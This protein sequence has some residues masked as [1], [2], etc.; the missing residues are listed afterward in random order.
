MD[1]L[2]QTYINGLA[3]RASRGS[4]D[5]FAELFAATHSLQY[6]YLRHMLD[7]EG[8]AEEALL[9]VYASALKR[10]STLTRPDLF[11]PWISRI[12]LLHCEEL[13]G[14]PE[15][16]IA[17]SD[18]FS[19]IMQL[20]LTESQI[21]VMGHLQGIS[22]E[23][24]SYM[25]NLKPTVIRRERKDA[26]RR[27][28][29]SGIPAGAVRNASAATA[30]RVPAKRTQARSMKNYRAAEIPAE[31]AGDILKSVF[32]RSGHEPNRMPLEALS[33]Y[34][35]Y[36]RDRFTLQRVVLGTGLAVFLLL[37]ALFILPGLTIVTAPVGER[38]LPVYTVETEKTLPVRRVTAVI[39]Q[40]NLP[41]YEAAAGVYTIEP[42]RNGELTVYV[43]LFN[44]QG[45]EK[46]VQVS[47]VEADAP[48][49]V[50]S[51]IGEDE[52]ELV[53]RDEGIGVD[54]REIRALGASGT[55]Y[56]PL[57]IDAGSG[58]VVFAYPEE[59]WDVY[60]PDHIGNTLHLKLTLE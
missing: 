51:L 30:S 10:I 6:A 3:S 5:A 8:M 37:P 56:Y 24:I 23:G 12:S 18:R 41:V 11:L 47:D 45:V 49:L 29:R 22:D 15:I 33:A 32:E 35:V 46:T 52:I 1:I 16:G 25:L 44:H 57:R 13:I 60:I 48:V 58:R 40:K 14:S 9:D 36:R 31:H 42:T 2:D 17:D 54:F 39:R 59:S 21:L 38:G 7:D 50:D 28:G 19:R 53:V 43:E 20:P 55:Q 26:L 27:L 4:A 34:A